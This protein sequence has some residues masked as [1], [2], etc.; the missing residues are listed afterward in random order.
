MSY[1]YR[2]RI[3]NQTN[4]FPIARLEEIRAKYKEKNPGRRIVIKFRGPRTTSI[5]HT[6]K[7]DAVFFAVYVH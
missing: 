6:Q 7:E 5:Y 2:P 4:V 1:V 3:L